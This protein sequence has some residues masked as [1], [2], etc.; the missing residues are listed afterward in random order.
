M[1]VNCV[2]GYRAHATDHVHDLLR[3]NVRNSPSLN[4][5]SHSVLFAR[6]QSMF[7]FIDDVAASR[8]RF[9]AMGR[10]DSHPNSNIT[11]LQ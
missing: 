11:N 6:W 5:H 4:H 7:D 8:E 2:Y 9:I 3:H 10:A 1:L